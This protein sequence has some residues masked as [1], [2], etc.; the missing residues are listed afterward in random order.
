MK[1]KVCGLNNPE[2]ALEV[3][4]VGP[5]MV[6]FV[7]HSA[8]P[9]LIRQPFGEE[10]NRSIP[11]NTKRVGVFVNAPLDAVLTAKTSYSLDVVQLH[12][13]ESPDYCSRLMG[14]GI[15]VIKAFSVDERFDFL[16]ANAFRHCCSM[17][18]FDASGPQGGGN[19]IPFRWALLNS[20]HLDHPFLLSG[21]ISLE[22]A[23][24]LRQLNHPA[25]LGV[26][27]NSRFEIS[28]GIKDVDRVR[29]FIDTIHQK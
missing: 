19:G 10:F 22:H 25:M 27:I 6:G 16:A 15:P 23:Q 12:G 17:F 11:S 2:N 18:L 9:R 4:L 8:S 29:E 5:D 14:L 26:D 21:G 7:F 24:Q 1:V 3:A 20:Y 13:G 28:P